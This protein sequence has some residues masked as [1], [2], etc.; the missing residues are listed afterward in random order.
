MTLHDAEV[1]AGA[2]TPGRL[3]QQRHVGRAAGGKDALGEL[4]HQLDLQGPVGQAVYFFELVEQVGEGGHLGGDGDLGQGNHEVFGEF[5][6]RRFEQRGDEQVEGTHA[7]VLQFLVQRLDADTDERRQDALGHAPGHFLGGA[8]GGGV[9]FVVG[10]VA[11]AVFEVDAEVFDGLGLELGAHPG[12]HRVGQVLGDSDGL[13]QI[14]GGGCISVEVSEGE[15]AE[16]AGGLCLI[17]LGAAVHGVQWLTLGGLAGVTHG[18]GKVGL[19]ES[20]ENLGGVEGAH[21]S[22]RGR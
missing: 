7:A 19:S 15:L 21:F 5:S 16:L 18:V 3:K 10:A 14:C 8:D 20:F 17:Q 12:V 1:G 2:P 6:A 13:T 22:F 11:V 4:N 9:F